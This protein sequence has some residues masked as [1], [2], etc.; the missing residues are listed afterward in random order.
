MK[1]KAQNP[2]AI[3]DTDKKKPGLNFAPQSPG[4]I[5]TSSNTSPDVSVFP[6]TLAYL[7]NDKKKATRQ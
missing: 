3:F 7:T 5:D 6:L 1:G 4:L 2:D